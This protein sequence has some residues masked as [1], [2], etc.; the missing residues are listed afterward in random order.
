MQ[1]FQKQ[2]EALE[3]MRCYLERYRAELDILR[4]NYKKDVDNMESD[5]VEKKIAETYRD[6]GYVENERHIKRVID[7][8]DEIDLPFFKRKIEKINDLLRS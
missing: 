2:L 5:G 4:G 3:K 1:D 6:H 8:I 7:N